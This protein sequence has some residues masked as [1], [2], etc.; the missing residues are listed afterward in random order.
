MIQDIF[1]KNYNVAF[2]MRNIDENSLVLSF[3][4]NKILLADEDAI[5]FPRYADMAFDPS[6]AQYLFEIDGSSFFMANAPDLPTPSGFTYQET[7]RFRTLEPRYLAFAGITAMHLHDWY[8]NNQYCGKCGE[9]LRHSNLERMLYCEACGNNV[10]PRISP[11][12]IVGVYRGDDLLL[13]RY[14][15]RTTRNYALIAGFVEI[16]ES[17]ED[18]VRREVMEEVGLKIKNLRYYKSQPWGLS[19]SLLMGY[20]AELDGDQEIVLETAELSEAVWTC[21][22]DIEATLDN[23]SLTNEMIVCF[24]NKKLP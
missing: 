6:Q 20:Y 8:Q 1:P 11:A 24:K 14:A 23:F 13:T 22:D 16:G 19:N 15:G 4:D 7:S 21:R 5:R 9:A 10:Y 18:T 17:V 2:S 3:V 12:I